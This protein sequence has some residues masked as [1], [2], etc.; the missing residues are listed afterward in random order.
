MVLLVVVHRCF[1]VCCMLFVEYCPLL[2][3]DVDVGCFGVWV[4]GVWCL[5]IWCLVFGVWC[6]VVVCCCLL[7]V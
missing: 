4:F 3:F 2:L 5:V 6:G 1:V 7:G